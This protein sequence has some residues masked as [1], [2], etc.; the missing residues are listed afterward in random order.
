MEA[1]EHPLTI[2]QGSTFQMQFR[3]ME[4]GRHHY[5][6]DGRYG[7]YAVAAVFV[8]RFLL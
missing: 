8:V 3:S 1:T 6:F 7:P 2:E 5:E 4:S